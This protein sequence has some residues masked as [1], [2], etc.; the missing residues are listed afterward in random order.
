MLALLKECWPSL[1][2]AGPPYGA[3]ALLKERWIEAGGRRTGA[4]LVDE[5]VFIVSFWCTDPSQVVLVL[6]KERPSASRYS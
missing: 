3:L 5:Q 2:S 1:S 4:V 6:F